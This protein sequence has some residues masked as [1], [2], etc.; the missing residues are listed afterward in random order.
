MQEG[1]KTISFANSLKR[2][3]RKWFG[4]TIAMRKETL[5]TAQQNAVHIFIFRKVL[6]YRTIN[7]CLTC[8]FE[9]FI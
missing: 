4:G 8:N 9:N 5:Y 7:G 1:I 3:R 6:P 2:I